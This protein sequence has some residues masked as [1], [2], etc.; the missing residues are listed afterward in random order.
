MSPKK[1]KRKSKTLL[2]GLG[3]ASAFGFGV[4]LKLPTHLTSAFSFGQ[5]GEA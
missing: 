4:S 5:P 3:G 1:A 2:S